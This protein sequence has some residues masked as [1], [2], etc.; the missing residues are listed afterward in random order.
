MRGT[1]LIT[2]LGLAFSLLLPAATRAGED[3]EVLG[4]KCAQWLK[5]LLE[6]ERP[7]ARRVAITALK[8]F[9]PKTD[10]VLQGLTLALEKDADPEIR[11]E[12]AQ[13]LG[14]MGE[15]AKLTVP[16]LAK[17]LAEDKEARVREAAAQ[18]L[19]SEM[20]P[21]SRTAVDELGKALKDKAAVVRT[22]AAS[23]LKDLGEEARPA[24]P[25]V[26]A[27]LK[28]GKDKDNQPAGRVFATQLTI[29]LAADGA[30]SLPVLEEVVAD[31]M[32]NPQ[33]RSAAAEAI[34]RFGDKAESAAAKLALVVIDVK[35][36]LALRQKALIALGKVSS[37]AK[38][39]WPAVRTALQEKDS[40]LRGQAVRVA[41]PLGK[42]EKEVVAVLEK[43]AK[44]DLNV[45]VRVAAI[46][47][48]G[49]L[50]EAAK[51]AEPTLSE[52]A[53]DPRAS[54]REA[55]RAALKRLR[56]PPAP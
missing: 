40:G 9:G 32:D 37:D 21:H 10:R 16:M 31:S 53:D 38:V 49:G 51:S 7:K 54:I 35:A 6:D 52:L 45:E 1:L 50:G 39:L 20:V 3:K 23:T 13:A 18:A 4:K 25:R 44:L 19:G 55:A 29:K 36:D 5:I 14:G 48:L 17:A 24:L 43:M 42:T 47:E 46:Q 8:I 26:L 15:D 41:G 34:G 56:A 30:T 2:S 12:A 11:R 33:V 22:A 27:Y 28:D